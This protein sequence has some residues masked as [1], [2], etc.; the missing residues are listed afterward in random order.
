MCGKKGLVGIREGPKET[1]KKSR[2]KVL[3]ATFTVVLTCTE[4]SGGLEE[5]NSPRTD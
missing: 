5:R 2:E 3:K 1:R 4:H